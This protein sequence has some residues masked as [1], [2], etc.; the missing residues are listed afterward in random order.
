ML[1][2]AARD[3]GYATYLSELGARQLSTITLLILLGMYVFF[4]LKKYPPSS[5][6]Y[7]LFLGVFWMLLTL[8]FEFGFGLYRG[9]T[10]SNLLN[11]YNMM[12]GHIWVLIP[13]WLMLAPYVFLKLQTMK[14]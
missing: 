1:N 3:L 6:A 2:G 10:L 11:D 13:I 4:I 8:G 5:G 9:N 14:S 7:A 12:Q